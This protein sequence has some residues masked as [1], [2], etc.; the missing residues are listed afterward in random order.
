MV[1]T[2]ESPELMSL[3]EESKASEEGQ[4]KELDVRNGRGKLK[5][6]LSVK[7]CVQIPCGKARLRSTSIIPTLAWGVGMCRLLELISQAA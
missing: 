7:T 5:E 4:Q 3:K 6:K 1:L 2:N